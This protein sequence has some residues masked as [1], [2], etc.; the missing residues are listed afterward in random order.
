[1]EA[2]GVQPGVVR[3]WLNSCGRQGQGRGQALGTQE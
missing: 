1:M 3:I 2:S